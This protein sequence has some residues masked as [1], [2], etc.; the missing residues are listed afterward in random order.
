MEVAVL[1]GPA[2]TNMHIA[3]IQKNTGPYVYNKQLR[4]ARHHMA[5]QVKYVVVIRRLQVN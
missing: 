2:H 1:C 4:S 3:Q 5:T